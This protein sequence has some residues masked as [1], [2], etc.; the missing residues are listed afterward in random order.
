[1][2]TAIGSSAAI[3]SNPQRDLATIIRQTS[4]SRIV[5]QDARLGERANEGIAE[6]FAQARFFEPQPNDTNNGLS[7]T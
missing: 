2:A 5:G 1:M 3:R 4:E 6:T 7:G